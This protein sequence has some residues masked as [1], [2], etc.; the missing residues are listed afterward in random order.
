MRVVMGLFV[1]S[2]MVAWMTVGLWGTV[3]LSAWSN[4]SMVYPLTIPEHVQTYDTLGVRAEPTD[5]WGRDA[6][7]VEL[8][9]GVEGADSNTLVLIPGFELHNGVIEVDVLSTLQE[10]AP[11]FAK[12]FVG[13]VFRVVGVGER[14]EGFY[15]RPVNARLD[16]QLNRNHSLQYFSYPDYPFSRL[17]EE[18][19]GQYES[20]ADLAMGKWI[21]LKVV[22]VDDR[23]ELYVN[24]ADQPSLIVTDLKEGAGG[25]G[26]IGLWVD[27]GTRA[28][29]SNLVVSP[30]D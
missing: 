14:F 30:W 13:L 11:A 7:E 28:Y 4:E 15:L 9:P 10:G 16:G 8:L 17:R 21:H 5:R 1:R 22:V 20:Y 26:T 6:L 12:G 19:P 24:D 27:V 2:V 23:A 18:A 29:F 3:P 25:S